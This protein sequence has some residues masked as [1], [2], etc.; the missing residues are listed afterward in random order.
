MLSLVFAES[1][2]CLTFWSSVHFS[3]HQQIYSFP[4]FDTYGHGLGYETPVN[5]FL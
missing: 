3:V 1:E 5:T 4:S 2:P